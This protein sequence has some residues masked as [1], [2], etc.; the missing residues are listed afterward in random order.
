MVADAPLSWDPRRLLVLAEVARS[1]SLAAAARRLRVSV[2]GLHYQ[3]DRLEREVGVRLVDRSGGRARLTV[4]GALLH[5]RAGGLLRELDAVAEQARRGPAELTPLRLV[6]PWPVA[7]GL[8]L[9]ALPDG[10]AAWGVSVQVVERAEGLRQVRDGLADVLVAAD[11]SGDRLRC[12]PE[13]RVDPLFAASYLVA[14]PR[15][16]QLARRSVVDVADAALRWVAPPGGGALTYWRMQ[17]H[18]LG[19]RLDEVASTDQ[20][21]YVGLIDTGECAGLAEPI[22]A[23]SVAPQTVLRPLRGLTPY[24]YFAAYRPETADDWRA[25]YLL[26]AFRAA[27]RAYRPTRDDL[28]KSPYG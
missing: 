17:R 18:R 1:G 4:A 26:D 11:W 3:L 22:L 13:V 23:G 8:L 15:S 28:S 12:G 9:P 19:I 6:V 14:L 7:S 21:E 5:A 16:G 10:P 24:R 27:G 20:Q 25:R 2:S